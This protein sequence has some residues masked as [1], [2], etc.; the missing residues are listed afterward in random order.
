MNCDR[1]LRCLECDSFV[2]FRL[3]AGTVLPSV[4]LRRFTGKAW[5]LAALEL[6]RQSEQ[7]QMLVASHLRFLFQPLTTRSTPCF[8]RERLEKN[9]P[10]E[11]LGAGSMIAALIACTQTRSISA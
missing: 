1:L 7:S 6:L 11:R 9:R 10:L 2:E 5:S 8:V 3:Q 4:S